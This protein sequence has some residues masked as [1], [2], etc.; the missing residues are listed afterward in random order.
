MLQT[1]W[2]TFQ[3]SAA[4]SWDLTSGLSNAAASTNEERSLLTEVIKEGFLEE[5][6]GAVP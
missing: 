1:G 6:A 3:R 4:G 2:A 5:G